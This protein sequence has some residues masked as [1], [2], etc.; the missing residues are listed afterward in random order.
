MGLADEVINVSSFEEC[1][2]LLPEAD[3]EFKNDSWSKDS[4]KKLILQK[5]LN[6]TTTKQQCLEVRMKAGIMGYKRLREA[7]YIKSLQFPS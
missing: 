4:Y 5:A 3:E 6:M 2:K 1:L 7:A